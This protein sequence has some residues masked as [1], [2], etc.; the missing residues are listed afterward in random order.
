MIKN[1]L[2]A[3]FVSAGAFLFGLVSVYLAMPS[4]APDVVAETQ[5]RVGPLS[6][7]SPAAGDSLLLPGAPYRTTPDSVLIAQARAEVENT[8]GQALQDSMQAQHDRL[9][10]AEARSGELHT[11]IEALR[12]EIGA[13]ELKRMQVVSLS[14]TLTR[15]EEDELGDIVQQLDPG[16]LRLLY[17]SASGRKR[18]RLLQAMS[19][20]QAAAFVE[21]VV[22]APTSARDRPNVAAN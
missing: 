9:A 5:Q 22:V 15:L 3:A 21:N 17:E 11:R 10:E 13:L 8:L 6:L 14:T 12:E 20:D 18:T 7:F 16:V 2:V 1:L 19:P 4:V